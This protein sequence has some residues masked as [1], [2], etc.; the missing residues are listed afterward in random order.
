[1]GGDSGAV[2]LCI[3]L[4]LKSGKICFANGTGFGFVIE[5]GKDTLFAEL[6]GA[7]RFCCLGLVG[8]VCAGLIGGIE[9]IASGFVYIAFWYWFWF[10]FYKI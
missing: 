5:R 3:I 2:A 4:S 1:M 7:S 8:D 6:T 10:F 9:L